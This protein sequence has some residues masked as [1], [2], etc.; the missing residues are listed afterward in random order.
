MFLSR[1]KFKNNSYVLFIVDE[2]SQYFQLFSILQAL[3]F[4]AP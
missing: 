3:F 1:S 2:F 4:Q